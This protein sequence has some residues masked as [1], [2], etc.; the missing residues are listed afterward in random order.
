MGTERDETPEDAGRAENPRHAEQTDPFFTGQP[1]S[2]AA[3]RFRIMAQFNGALVEHSGQDPVLSQALQFHAIY[4]NSIAVRPAQKD[5]GE[6]TVDCTA[7]LCFNGGGPSTLSR[8]VR[9]LSGVRVGQTMGEISNE[10]VYNLSSHPQ[11]ALAFLLR[12]CEE[13]PDKVDILP[14][15]SDPD[16]LNLSADTRFSNDISFDN[17]PDPRSQT[18]MKKCVQKYMDYWEILQEKANREDTVRVGISNGGNP[19]KLVSYRKHPNPL[20]RFNS[21][22]Y[23]EGKKKPHNVTTGSIF[24]PGGLEKKCDEIYPYDRPRFDFAAGS[25]ENVHSLVR[26]LLLTHK[27]VHLDIQLEGSSNADVIV[28]FYVQNESPEE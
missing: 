21:L 20:G 3:L 4:S 15:A 17:L 22:L 27:R 23:P 10:V 8:P 28:T 13:L 24:I 16:N 26:E 14:S 9:L 18:D 1:E 25:I 12:I 11:D 19:W 5:T 2:I 7:A 6:F